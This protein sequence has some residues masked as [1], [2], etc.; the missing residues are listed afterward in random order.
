MAK[1]TK[2]LLIKYKDKVT[3]INRKKEENANKSHSAARIPTFSPTRLLFLGVNSL[4]EKSSIGPINSN[5]QGGKERLLKC[6]SQE[7]L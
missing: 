6:T 2:I 5:Y 7:H 3:D 1:Q 4:T